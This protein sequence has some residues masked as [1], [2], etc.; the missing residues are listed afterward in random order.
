MPGM[1]SS[2]SFFVSSQSQDSGARAVS[3]LEAVQQASEIFAFLFV[4]TFIVAP[5]QFFKDILGALADVA[6]LTS[7]GLTQI[8]RK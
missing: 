6:I 7:G 3:P 2:L 8:F 4:V 5:A 1:T